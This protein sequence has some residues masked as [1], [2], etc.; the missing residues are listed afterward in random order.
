MLIRN[1]QIIRKRTIIA[2]TN[3]GNSFY[4]CL[5]FSQPLFVFPSFFGCIRIFLLLV[6]YH[7]CAE[8]CTVIVWQLPNAWAWYATAK[9]WIYCSARCIKPAGATAHEHHAYATPHF[10]TANR[11]NGT[12]LASF[13]RARQEIEIVEN[14]REKIILM[15][16]SPHMHSHSHLCNK[17]I[18]TWTEHVYIWLLLHNHFII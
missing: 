16:I 2:H 6:F 12:Q 7:L 5:F 17:I 9:R 3:G 4:C 18:Y 15:Y 8:Y 1:E 11:E 10:R 13:L 14:K